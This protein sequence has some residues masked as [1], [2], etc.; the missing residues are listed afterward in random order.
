MTM[1]IETCEQYVLMQLFE[2]QDE[3]DRLC[4]EL[5]RRDERIDELT[6]QIEAARSPLQKAIVGEGRKALY[7][8]CAGYMLS[9]KNGDEIMTF[10]DWCLEDVSRYSLPKGVTMRSF[11]DEFEDELREEYSRQVA[12]EE[13]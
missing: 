3:N 11:I 1:E 8:N 4:R 6:R 12:E 2:Q 9:A 7:G 10:E 13:R 5:Q